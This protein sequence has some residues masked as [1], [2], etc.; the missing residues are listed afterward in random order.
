MRGGDRRTKEL[1]QLSRDQLGPPATTKGLPEGVARPIESMHRADLFVG[2]PVFSDA[3]AVSTVIEMVGRGLLDCYPALRSVLIVAVGD[4]TDQTRRLAEL[5]P[6]PP[7]VVRLVAEHPGPPGKGRALRMVFQAA[8][9]LQ[10]RACLVIEP[11]VRSVQPAW[12]ELLAQPILDGGYDFVAPGYL[13]TPLD[14]PLEDLLTYPLTRALYRMG[15]RHPLGG[16]FALSY[17]FLRDLL[18]L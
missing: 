18:D 17:F 7:Q 15:V 16:D 10:A 1:K 8:R 9:Y 2:I 3:P 5:A 11:D 4:A 14:D 12:V 6:V 13:R